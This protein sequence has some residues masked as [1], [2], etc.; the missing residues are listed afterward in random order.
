M[1]K[2]LVSYIVTYGFKSQPSKVLT[3]PDI[4]NP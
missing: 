4:G 1:A 3:A 2:V